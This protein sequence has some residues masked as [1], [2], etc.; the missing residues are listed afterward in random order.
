MERNSC[1]SMK[2]P[3]FHRIKKAFLQSPFIFL[4]GMCAFQCA[5]TD[6]YIFLWLLGGDVDGVDCEYVPFHRNCISSHHSTHDPS[7]THIKTKVNS[8]EYN[9]KKLNITARKKS[10]KILFFFFFSLL[11]LF[12]CGTANRF[13]SYCWSD[14]KVVLLQFCITTVNTHSFF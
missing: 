14:K 8:Q 12:I 10:N 2:K 11:L 9:R 6:V 13:K 3:K 5:Q 7:K 1:L 4:V